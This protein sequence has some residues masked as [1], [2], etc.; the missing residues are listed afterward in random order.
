MIWPQQESCCP[1]KTSTQSTLSSFLNQYLAKTYVST[2]SPFEADVFVR[3]RPSC[4]LVSHENAHPGIQKCSTQIGR[5]FD[6]LPTAR[7]DH[8]V[9]Q[10]DLIIRTRKLVSILKED[11]H[12]TPLA[13]LDRHLVKLDTSP[14]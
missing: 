13:D 7:Y 9:V 12:G 5:F 8:H 2:P 6:A 3:P 11:E 4:V 1:D 14:S 10:S